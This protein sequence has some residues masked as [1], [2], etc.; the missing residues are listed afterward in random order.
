[1]DVLIDDIVLILRNLASLVAEMKNGDDN[2]DNHAV[3]VLKCLV[4]VIY[5]FMKRHSRSVTEQTPQC[6]LLAS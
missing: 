3:G 6:R 2:L 1:M 5:S 4:L